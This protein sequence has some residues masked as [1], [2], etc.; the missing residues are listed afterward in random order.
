MF[1]WVLC[2][3]HIPQFSGAR[4]RPS[5]RSE[6]CNV[7]YQFC[8]AGYEVKEMGMLQLQ[9]DRIFELVTVRERGT[10]S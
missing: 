9:H 6:T 8:V 2:N 1:H 7:Q 4:Q 5:Q 10:V 3:C